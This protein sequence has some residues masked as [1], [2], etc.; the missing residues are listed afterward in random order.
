MKNPDA[1]VKFAVTDI[2]NQINIGL[3]PQ[4]ATEKVAKELDLN[5]N[6]I[7][8]A[9]E[10]INVALHYNHFKK[11]ADA[12]AD[13]FPIVDAQVAVENIFGAKEKTASEFR[14]ELLSS[15][16]SEEI[17]PKFARYLETGP[18]K[19]AYEKILAEKDVKFGLSEAGVYEKSANY[20]RDLKKTAEDKSGEAKE[21]EFQVNR[22]FC[23]ILEK[24]AKA[25]DYRASFA[26]FESQAFSLYGEKAV[27][28]IDLL[29]KTSQ[30]K[31]ARGTHDVNYKM[32]NP[33]QE[34]NMLGEFLKKAE[35]LST[36]VKEAE[37]AQHNYK[38]EKDYATDIFKK[39]GS[40]LIKGAEVIADGSILEK[41][42]A[43]MKKEA[44]KIAAIPEEDP[45]MASIK[46][47]KEASLAKE[48][49]R[50][51]SAFEFINTALDIG[52]DQGKPSVKATTSSESDNRDRAFL[53]QELATTDPIL[54]KLPT[55]KVV[56][57]YQQLLRI[58]PE[59]SKEKELVRSFLRQS[60][61]S[62]A[63][64]PFEGQQLVEANTKLLKQRMMQQGQGAPKDKGE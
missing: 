14:S 55:H 33:A 54:A 18:Y 35:T 48:G 59:I 45:V 2:V 57:S 36:I 6:F 64:G 31:E 21:A 41:L 1:L 38:F 32:F 4:A 58:A 19:E 53:L 37:D 13:D 7:K 24:F 16:Q 10:A 62:Q 46:M 20:L 15:F 5:P 12:K 30:L 23:S 56:D 34:V 3:T 61:A 29:Y 17:S 8:R 51:K 60:T 49:E 40:E 44:V 42:E 39:R 50:I 26:D 27:P 43:E 22:S 25:E 52:K 47:K 28:Y 63:I 9:A 11:H